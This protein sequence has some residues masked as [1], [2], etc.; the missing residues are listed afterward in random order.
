MRGNKELDQFLAAAFK[1]MG[2]N[3]EAFVFINAT[4][5]VISDAAGGAMRE[6]KISVADRDYFKAASQGK[7][8]IGSPVKSK[9]TGNPI[10]GI[11]IPLK[12]KSGQFAGIF[13]TIMKLDTLSDKI[14][15]VTLGKSGYPFMIDQKGMVLA[16]PKKDFILN[17]D[18]SEIKEMESLYAHMAGGKTGVDEYVFQGIEK[19]AGFAPVPITGWSIAAN[20]STA[21]F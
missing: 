20:Q 8:F 4:G 11:A 18:M 12:T 13:A 16:H 6:K 5:I 17:V 7:I 14:T 19:T 1:E 9:T 21:E 10:S 3:Y 2:S 15:G